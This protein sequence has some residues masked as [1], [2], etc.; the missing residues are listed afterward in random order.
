MAR[1]SGHSRGQVC[2]L[3]VAWLLAWVAMS[4]GVSF[5]LAWLIKNNRL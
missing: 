5:G 3:D 1:P 4:V 2:R